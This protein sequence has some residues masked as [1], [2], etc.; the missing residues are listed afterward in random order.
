V[1]PRYSSPNPAREI[2]FNLEKVIQEKR[3]NVH[4][5][6]VKGGEYPGLDIVK[7]QEKSRWK[8]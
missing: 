5:D 1:N 8:D 7:R 2:N 4:H 3:S 6:I